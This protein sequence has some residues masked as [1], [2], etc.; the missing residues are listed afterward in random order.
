M[1]NTAGSGEVRREHLTAR[2]GHVSSSGDLDDRI[3]IDRIVESP[4][5]A[6]VAERPQSGV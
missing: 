1:D 3:A 6:D 2:L 4:A 5:D